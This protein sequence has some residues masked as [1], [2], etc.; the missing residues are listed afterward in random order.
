MRL[1]RYRLFKERLRNLVW[2]LKV[3]TGEYFFF[4]F[5]VKRRVDDWFDIF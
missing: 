5:L 2:L 3:N 4:V 1:K